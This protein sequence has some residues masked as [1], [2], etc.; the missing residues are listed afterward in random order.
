MN[1]TDFKA[2]LP[3]VGME[4]TVSGQANLTGTLAAPQG[5]VAVQGRGLRAAFYSRSIP[6]ASFDVRAQLNGDR[7][8]LDARFHAGSNAE[9]ALTGTAPLNSAVA[10][11]LR[12]NGNMDLVM[13]D[14]ILAADGR[15]VR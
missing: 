8:T 13:L 3:A 15:R 7:A 2:F 9:L 6:S 4:G 10:M 1:V 14:P 12:A 5:G 11:N